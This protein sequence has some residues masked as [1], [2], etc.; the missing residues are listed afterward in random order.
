MGT[1]ASSQKDGGNSLNQQS[2]A[3]PED[4]PFF[5]AINQPENLDWKIGRNDDEIRA[6]AQK[7]NDLPA[8]ISDYLM[9]SDAVGAHQ[10]PTLQA[11]GVTHLIN[12]AGHDGRGDLGAYEAAG[13]Q[14]L[15]IDA[16]D[17]YE[18]PLLQVCNAHPFPGVL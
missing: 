12:L 13:I 9:I 6:I 4:W 14:V 7:Q 10:V 5:W 16:E 15:E 17:T 1:S 11:F 2:E 8:E 3:I 18:Y